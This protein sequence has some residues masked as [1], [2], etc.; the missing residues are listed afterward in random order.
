MVS[1]DRN[2]ITLADKEADAR[3][4]DLRITPQ[5]EALNNLAVGLK[6]DRFYSAAA[7][8]M[9]R[10]VNLCPD[11]GFLWN[12]LGSVLWN[13]GRYEEA[14]AA[15]ARSLQLIGDEPGVMMNMGMLLSSLGRKQ[16][17]L[18][19]LR[20]TCEK[21]PKDNHARWS[22]ALGLLDHGEWP[23][24]FREYECRMA[25]RGPKYY[26][27]MPYP[28]WQGEDLGGKT[29]FIQAE[30]GV[31]D[32]LLFSRYLAW[33][34][35]VWP[36]AN[37]KVL[38]SSRDQV[39]LE[40]ILHLYT[41]RYA[42]EF[43]HHGIPWPKC[44]YG[45]FL[46]SIANIYG[47]ST[48][49]VPPDP[50]LIRERCMAEKGAIAVP[51]PLV[52]SI[53]VGVCWSGNPAM[54][55]NHERSIPA[56]LLLE[57]ESDPNVQLYS[58]QFGDDG[59]QRMNASELICDAASDIGDRGLLGTGCVMLNLDLIITCCT[60]NAHLAGSLGVPTWVLLCY[61]PYWCWL[62]GRDDSVWYGDHLRLFRQRAPGDWRELIDRVRR[63]LNIYARLM[64]EQR[65][66]EG[67][68]AN[69]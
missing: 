42:I 53:K 12:G 9:R 46:M 35:K 38:I 16:E 39:N 49:C 19:Y 45:C 44:D 13:M 31:G 18:D 55:R 61:D 59:L 65:A 37:L 63:E 2:I 69:G 40:A 60:A 64:L 66:R 10:A 8:A 52:P 33:V 51:E 30:Q 24:G 28:T 67:S 48:T 6:R 4:A 17:A 54:D 36:T 57:L 27:K 7:V 15:L 68:Q 5:A 1:D 25:Y 11:S 22:Y 21:L 29:L 3:R 23:T 20:R 34:C 56:E 32:R 50:G 43:L 14:H 26:P 47:T 62:R 58:L 41:E